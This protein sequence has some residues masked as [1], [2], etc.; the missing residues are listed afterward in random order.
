MHCHSENNFLPQ[1]G[2]K[3]T[4]TTN[5]IVNKLTHSQNKTHSLTHDSV[6]EI[7]R[8]N[9]SRRSASVSRKNRSRSPDSAGLQFDTATSD[10][11]PDSQLALPRRL[12]VIP[13]QELS[14]GAPVSDERRFPG[15]IVTV[16][17]ICGS[18]ARHSD[19]RRTARLPA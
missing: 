3:I 10:G 16:F 4:S 19:I 5:R 9:S 17:Q 8:W 2:L 18:S 13:W 14:V 7:V 12:I 15:K 1:G 11:P 6:A